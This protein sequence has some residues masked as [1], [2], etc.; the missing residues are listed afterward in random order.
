MQPLNVL[1][2][3]SEIFPLVKTGGLADVI[4]ALPA[5]LAEQ[6]VTVRT[7][8]P[9]YPA[10]TEAIGAVQ[11]VRNYSDLFA[12]RRGCWM[13]V[14]P[15]SICWYSMPHISMQGRA[16]PI[17]VRMVGTGRT[18]P[19]GLLRCR[20]PRRRSAAALCKVYAPKS[21]IAH[22]WQTGLAPA[23]LHYRGG[24]RREP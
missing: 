10:V 5:A 12:A 1:S 13:P 20:W 9:G 6:G 23:Y 15:V 4:G 3:A 8:I 2:V 14:L 19:Y 18:M 22:D 21:C 24:P 7:L 17:L 11:S 16:I